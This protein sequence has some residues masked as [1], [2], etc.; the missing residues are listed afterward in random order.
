VLF[1]EDIDRIVKGTERTERVDRILNIVD[2]VNTKSSRVFIV[3]TTNDLSAIRVEMLREGRLDV[4]LHLTPPDAEAITRL[5]KVYGRGMV[6]PDA[7]LMEAGM[8]LAG[9]VPATVREVIERAKFSYVRRM[10]GDISNVIL[11][12]EDILRAS[13][14]V[15]RQRKDIQQSRPPVAQ[16]PYVEAADR[17]A[18]AVVKTGSLD[19][20]VFGLPRPSRRQVEANEPGERE[21]FDQDDDGEPFDNDPS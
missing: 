8:V 3:L 16:H 9:T 1:A 19:S 20:T 17:I 12:A 7:N 18:K 6:D 4:T 13:H 15:M 11:T 2:G 5:I 14:S 21:I 10:K